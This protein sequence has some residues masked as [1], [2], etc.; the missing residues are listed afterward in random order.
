M[1]GENTSVSSVWVDLSTTSGVS[2][3][4]PSPSRR[5]EA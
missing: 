1:D 2:L 3:Q 4:P 5:E